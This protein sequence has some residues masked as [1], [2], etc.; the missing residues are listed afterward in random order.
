[1]G[2]HPPLASFLRIQQPRGT[3]SGR[4]LNSKRPPREC[5]LVRTHPQR[6][7]ASTTIPVCRISCAAWCSL[8]PPASPLP[9]CSRHVGRRWSHPLPRLSRRP[10]RSPL[11]SRPPRRSPLPTPSRRPLLPR[12]PLPHPRPLATSSPPHP[13][14]PLRPHASLLQPPHSTRRRRSPWDR[15]PLRSSTTPPTA[16]TEPT[17]P[18]GS[19]TSPAA[20]GTASPPATTDASPSCSSKATGSAERSPPN[21]AVCPTSP[22]C[23]STSTG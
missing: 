20:P 21:W 17:A 23:R 15:I 8:A 19:V 10:R 2:G 11:L 22:T 9:L 1:M 6:R 16:Q 3:V 14:P 7:P 18:T 13:L 5:S 12:C 4:P